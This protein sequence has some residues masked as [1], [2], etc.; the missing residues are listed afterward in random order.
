MAT[1]KSK[2]KK[3]K[4]KSKGEVSQVNDANFPTIKLGGAVTF[5]FHFKCPKLYVDYSIG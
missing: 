4:K 1:K 3:K 5:N 2:K